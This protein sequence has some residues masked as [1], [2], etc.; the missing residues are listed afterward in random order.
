MDNNHNDDCNQHSAH[1]DSSL[2]DS[3]KFERGDGHN[4]DDDSND[5]VVVPYI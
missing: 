5:D 1:I 4:K 3:N 2:K